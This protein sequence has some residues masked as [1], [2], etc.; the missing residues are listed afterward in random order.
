MDQAAIR[1][2]ICSE[3]TRKRNAK[4]C[5]PAMTDC[6]LATKLL[7]NQHLDASSLPPSIPYTAYSVQSIR[8]CNFSHPFASCTTLF[9]FSSEIIVVEGAAAA[10][11]V[12]TLKK[13]KYCYD[14][15]R[16]FVQAPDRR[17]KH[18]AVACCAV[19]CSALSLLRFWG[20]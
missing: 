12:F 9:C 2:D 13:A 18:T 17:E 16:V 14:A 1:G 19:L 7:S 11:G 5:S 8:S 10:S 3:Q 20:F 6:F 15:M 4:T